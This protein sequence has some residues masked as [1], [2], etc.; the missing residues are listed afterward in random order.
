MVL[1]GCFII[2]P[3]RAYTKAELEKLSRHSMQPFQDTRSDAERKAYAKE[4]AVNRARNADR[5]EWETY[6]R[7]LPDEA[8][9]RF[10]D[11]RRGKQANS[12]RYQE[13]KEE[14]KKQL[15]NSSNFAILNEKEEAAVMEYIS[16][17][18]YILNAK[19][20]EKMPL[21]PYEERTIQLMD[22]ALKKLPVYQGGVLRTLNFSNDEEA[23]D[24]VSKHMLGNDVIYDA[25]TSTSVNAGYSENPSI[26]LKIKSF[27]GRDLRKYN[28]E[29]GE[30]LFARK[31]VF[32]VLSSSIKDEIIVYEMEEKKPARRLSQ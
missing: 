15:D 4:Q 8:Y 16:G 9:A 22:S 28:E 26:I 29:E 7:A 14:Y 23:L 10:S 17:G 1:S 12:Q 13:L 32:R 31:T 2:K 24:F 20:R 5:R 30:V 21:E 19:L 11:F 3:P 27:T 18:S 6:R 25:Y